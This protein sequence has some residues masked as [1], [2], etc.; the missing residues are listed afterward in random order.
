MFCVGVVH[1]SE[2]SGVEYD[3]TRFIYV[4]SKRSNV[5]IHSIVLIKLCQVA[6]C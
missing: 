4:A 1:N 5:P 3:R 2:N 6:K